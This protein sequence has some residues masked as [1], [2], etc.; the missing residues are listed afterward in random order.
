ME[1]S[2]DWD[3]TARAPPYTKV[4]RHETLRDQWHLPR[5]GPHRSPD[6]ATLLP[7]QEPERV[8]SVTTT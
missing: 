1:P 6:I 4:H 3:E 8:V 7:P 2:G 5:S